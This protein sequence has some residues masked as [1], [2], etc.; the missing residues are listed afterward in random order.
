MR[1][2]RLETVLAATDLEPTS[3][4]ALQTAAALAG[5][6]GATLHVA[7]VTSADHGTA[8]GT[9]SHPASADAVT[10]ALRRAGLADIDHRIHVA[11]GAPAEVLAAL[12][13]LVGAD[14]VVIGRHRHDAQEAPD[15]PVGGTARAVLAHTLAPCL[16]TS[17][18]LELPIE[19][20]LVA[21]DA[22][23]AARGALIVALSWCSAL[24]S[25]E[26]GAIEPT[27]TALHVDAGG[28]SSPAARHMRRTIDHELQL[29]RRKAGDWAGVLVQM[30]TEPGADPVPVVGSYAREHEPDLL[31]LGTRGLNADNAVRLGSVSIAM[32]TQSRVPV[33]LVPPAVWRDYVRDFDYF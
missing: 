9:G 27:L 14:V 8:E 25:R 29:L 26:E 1:L 24:R 2:L 12:S 31:V 23:E 32:T 10:A 16:V 6:A 22:S 19:R 7:H 30:V 17:R 18:R 33:L 11:P 28:D 20:A 3:D 4:A 21:I 5:A 15:R 13:E